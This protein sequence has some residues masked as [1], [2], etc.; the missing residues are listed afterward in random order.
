MKYV[1]IKKGCSFILVGYSTMVAKIKYKNVI[2]PK[3][4]ER[5]SSKIPS[6]YTKPLF[7]WIL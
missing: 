1:K 7:L 2:R 3:R 6:I 5:E 4:S